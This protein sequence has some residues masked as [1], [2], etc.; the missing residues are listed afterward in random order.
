M[1][2]LLAAIE[3]VLRRRV[4]RAGDRELDLAED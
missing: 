3:P 4:G 1:T 2:E